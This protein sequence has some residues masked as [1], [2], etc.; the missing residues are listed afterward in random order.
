MREWILNIKNLINLNNYAC[1]K[2]F[3]LH[4]LFNFLG[5]PPSCVRI[6]GYIKRSIFNSCNFNLVE[7][8][9]I[10]HKTRT[11]DTLLQMEN[12]PFYF[13]NVLNF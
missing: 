2:Y 1:F 11:E 5:L 10:E 4:L 12:T 7:I 13:K 6:S 9:L 3:S 8:S